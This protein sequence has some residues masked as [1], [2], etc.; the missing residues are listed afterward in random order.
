M[1]VVLFHIVYGD[2]DFYHADPKI[3]YFEFYYFCF[4]LKFVKPCRFSWLFSSGWLGK[5]DGQVSQF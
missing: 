1:F 2:H 3:I 5:V 4:S